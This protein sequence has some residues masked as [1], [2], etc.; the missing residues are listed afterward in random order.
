M[1]TLNCFQ[2][3][4]KKF[5]VGEGLNRRIKLRGRVSEIASVNEMIDVCQ[6]EEKGAVAITGIGGMGYL[7]PVK[8]NK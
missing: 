1:N 7:V 5:F 2:P 4:E 3:R 8:R 6:E